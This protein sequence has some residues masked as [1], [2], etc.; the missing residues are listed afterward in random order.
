V[1]DCLDIT[2]RFLCIVISVLVSF[3][4][5]CCYKILTLFSVLIVFVIVERQLQCI[6]SACEAL[7]DRFDFKCFY[8]SE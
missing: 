7:T 3:S 8:S 2:L 4:K 1:L 6:H 5:I